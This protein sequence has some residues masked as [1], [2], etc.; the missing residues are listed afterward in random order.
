MMSTDSARREGVFSDSAATLRQVE[1]VLCE[2]GAGP[3]VHDTHLER[4]IQGIENRS[5]DLQD[6]LELVLVTRGE[7]LRVID[8]VRERR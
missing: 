7:I 4:I 5:A 3:S 1:E 8:L 6:L 2:L